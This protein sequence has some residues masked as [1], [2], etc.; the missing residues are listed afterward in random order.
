MRFRQILK[1]TCQLIFLPTVKF[2]DSLA[3]KNNNNLNALKLFLHK[4]K[5]TEGRLHKYF[6]LNLFRDC[7]QSEALQEKQIKISK[8]IY[9]YIIFLSISRVDAS[10]AY[11]VYN[12]VYG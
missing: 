8:Y 3:G 10:L 11:P 4:S 9:I 1:D 12:L 5:T 2:R 6:M 7:T